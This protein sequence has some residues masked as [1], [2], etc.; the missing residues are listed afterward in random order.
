MPDKSTKTI[1][2]GIATGVPE[3][4]QSQKDHVTALIEK[5]PVLEAI[6]RKKLVS[7]FMNVAIEKR[8]F[9][10]SYDLFGNFTIEEKMKAFTK[11]GT[12]LAVFVANHALKKANTEPKEIARLVFV[13]STE[14]QSPGLD[15]ILIDKLSLPRNV[16]RSNI[17]FKGCLGGLSGLALINDYCI[18][19]P[20]NKGAKNIFDRFHCYH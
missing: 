4:F 19:N 18:A 11:D 20:G 16:I 2:L 17:N 1:I 9:S 14:L 5:E 13:T 8:H 15:V 12:D 3:N 7:L 10:K 6:D